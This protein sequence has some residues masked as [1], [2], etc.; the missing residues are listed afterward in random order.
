M[1]Q[2]AYSWL[3]E[4]LGLK[5]NQVVIAKIGNLTETGG[6]VGSIGRG[7]KILA[8]PCL[9]SQEEAV[10]IGIQK[11]DVNFSRDVINPLM[12]EGKGQKKWLTG[13]EYCV[14]PV[15]EN[16]VQVKRGTRGP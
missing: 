10:W 12:M 5:M 15:R 1:Q 16:K 8:G 9:S 7:Y 14:G 3:P 13:V 4:T 11:G 6:Q 2:E